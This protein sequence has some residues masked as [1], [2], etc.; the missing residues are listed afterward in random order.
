MPTP[1]RRGDSQAARLRG[2][3]RLRANS[4]PHCV[5]VRCVRPRIVS[6]SPDWLSRV[7]PTPM[8]SCSPRLPGFADA[9][10]RVDGRAVRTR[11]RRRGCGRDSRECLREHLAWKGRNT[12]SDAVL[13]GYDP[14]ALDDGE[15]LV[16]G[17][18]RIGNLFWGQGD[19][20]AADD[21]L[22]LV[23]ERITDPVLSQIVDG[24]ASACALSPVISRVRSNCPGQGARRVRAA[25]VGHRVGGLRW[26]ARAR[27]RWPRR[28]GGRHRPSWAQRGDEHRWG[29]CDFRR[30]SVRFWR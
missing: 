21:V 25:A 30:A 23:R 28:R 20:S 18:Q 5:P 14:A 3:R 9:R 1:F 6:G 8:P 29:Y 19:V 17:L 12:E 2:V 15:L 11:R 10:R 26:R 13:A 22:A 24:I 16:W 4:S 27:P 7:M